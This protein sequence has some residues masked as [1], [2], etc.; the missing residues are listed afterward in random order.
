MDD[1]KLRQLMQE[2]LEMEAQQIMDEVNSDPSL[3]DVEVPQEVHD[4]LFQQIREY[5]EQKAKANLSE[6]DK[7]L[8][9][10]GKVYKRNRK[11]NRYLVLAAAVIAVLAIGITSFGG[12]V[13]MVETVK[14]MV[15]NREQTRIDVGDDKSTIVK[16][17]SEEEA[18]QLI[19]DTFNYAPPR[20][21]RM[22][23]DMVFSD[24]VVEEA[25]QS[26]KMFYASKDDKIIVYTM[27]FNYRP[28]SI[29]YDIE[30]D[31]I[32][33]YS[34]NISGH[35]ITVKQHKV[36]DG[37]TTRWSIQFEE[38]KM[39]GFLNINGLTQEQVDEIVKNIYFSK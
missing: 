7:E 13:K 30:D 19:N 33:E 21:L 34:E 38:Q 6:E 39:S 29:G 16:V 28:S 10:L 27:F 4:K 5:E 36:E 35:N 9:R 22:P 20:V 15:L 32:Q 31:I 14:Q 18:Y 17:A 1:A 23:Q 2:N 12:P 8:I 25:T 24:V 11:R 3:A 37:N 26:A